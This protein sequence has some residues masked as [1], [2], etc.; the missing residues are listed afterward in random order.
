MGWNFAGPTTGRGRV[1]EPLSRVCPRVGIPSR[2][3]CVAVPGWLSTRQRGW[4]EIPRCWPLSAGMS[5]PSSV[6]PDCSSCSVRPTNGSPIPSFRIES[7]SSKGIRSVALVHCP[8]A[9]SH[10]LRSCLIPCI[11]RVERPARFL[12]KA[13]RLFGCSMPMVVAMIPKD[14]SLPHSQL[15]P[16]GFFSSVLRKLLRSWTA[17]R[18][19]SVGSKLVRWDA[20]ELGAE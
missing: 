2:N 12:R 11:R 20:W 15:R 14:S 18:P 9:F 8:R 5:W 17:R 10:R 1:S 7:P 16:G 3:F 6:S 19:F 13:C 4:V